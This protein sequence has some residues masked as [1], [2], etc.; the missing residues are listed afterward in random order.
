VASVER[1]KRKLNRCRKADLKSRAET[2]TTWLLHP[3][4]VE[5]TGLFSP[6]LHPEGE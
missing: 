4:K 6:A 3:E 2:D 5:T 1:Q